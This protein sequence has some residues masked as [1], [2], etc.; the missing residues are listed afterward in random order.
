MLNCTAL[1]PT[2]HVLSRPWAWFFGSGLSVF[3]AQVQA[4]GQ[5]SCGGT[6]HERL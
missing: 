1:F 5:G 4:V 6:A 2:L 3:G